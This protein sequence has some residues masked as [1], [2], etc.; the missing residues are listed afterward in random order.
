M[1][2]RSYTALGKYPSHVWCW[3]RW[4]SQRLQKKRPFGSGMFRHVKNSPRV[5][6]IST[7]PDRCL[8][9]W[10]SLVVGH[11]SSTIEPTWWLI[12]RLSGL[13]H[14]RYKWIN[15][16]CPIY[17]WG[18]KQFTSRG[19]SHQVV[20]QLA[21]RSRETP[22]PAAHGAVHCAEVRW[23]QGTDWGMGFW[24]TSHGF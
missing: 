19:M 10:V 4:F 24:Y 17:S 11:Y 8:P 21:L 2:P 7:V 12:P 20:P 22:S 1:T 9:N 16:T 14:P 13:V 3:V 15:P 5:C 23:L 18:Y 6:Q